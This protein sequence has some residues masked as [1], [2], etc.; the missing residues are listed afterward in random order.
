MSDT[1]WTHERRCVWCGKTFYGHGKRLYCCD[2]HRRYAEHDRAQ[3]RRR[4]DDVSQKVA[5]E[6][7]R[8]AVAGLSDHDR[9]LLT[10][11]M[12]DSRRRTKEIYEGESDER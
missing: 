6:M 2:T 1:R 12:S 3:N 8:R 4:T 10:C 7:A 11:L 9:L 5:D